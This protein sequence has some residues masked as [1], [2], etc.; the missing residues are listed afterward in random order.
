MSGGSVAILQHK[1]KSQH[2]KEV[3]VKIQQELALVRPP[4]DLFC[5]IREVPCSRPSPQ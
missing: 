1:V 4:L 5:S 2:T 3:T